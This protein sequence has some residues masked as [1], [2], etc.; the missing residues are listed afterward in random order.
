M[1]STKTMLIAAALAGAAYAAPAASSALIARGDL[2]PSAPHC[3][4]KSVLE[5]LLHVVVCIN[6]IIKDLQAH[7]TIPG[8]INIDLCVKAMVQITAVLKVA[9]EQIKVIISLNLTLEGILAGATIEA[10]VKAWLNI[11][12]HICLS[13]NACITILGGIKL[14]VVLYVFINAIVQLSAQVVLLLNLCIQ[15]FLVVKVDLRA[16][17]C[18]AVQANVKVIADIKLCGLATVLAIL[19]IN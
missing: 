18:A 6:I 5:V 1:I 7:V 15:L 2:I 12:I 3:D 11:F 16:L 17:I 4:C 10:I 8:I 13:V 19:K 14:H 9:I